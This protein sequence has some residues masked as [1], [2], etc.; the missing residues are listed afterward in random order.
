MAPTSQAQVS[1]MM[2]SDD[3][4]TEAARSTEKETRSPVSNIRLSAQ[5]ASHLIRHIC[6]HA[7]ISPARPCPGHSQP[8]QRRDVEAWNVPGC[9]CTI[10][11]NG[12]IAT[13][14]KGR[15]RCWWRRRE[16]ERVKPPNQYGRHLA[17]YRIWRLRMVVAV[18]WGISF[19]LSP[20]SRSNSINVQLSNRPMT[21]DW[22][23]CMR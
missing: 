14:G 19:L 23:L 1:K 16:R 21:W 17:H 6:F 7:S 11:I 9:L 22:A 3:D 13:P 12:R 2:E 18:V 10:A 4:T 15:G 20:M 5:N 8:G